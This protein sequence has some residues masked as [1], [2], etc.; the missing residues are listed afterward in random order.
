MS[1]NKCNIIFS[2]TKMEVFPK[3]YKPPGT[4]TQLYYS[5]TTYKAT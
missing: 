4:V 1:L 5:I 2:E 3:T